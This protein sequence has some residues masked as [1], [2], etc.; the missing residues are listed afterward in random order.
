MGL[1]FYVGLA[2]LPK[3]GTQAYRNE[4]SAGHSLRHAA[5]ALKK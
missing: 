1:F 3:K 4:I 5:K 2:K